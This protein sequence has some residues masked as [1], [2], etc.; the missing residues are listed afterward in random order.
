MEEELPNGPTV[1]APGWRTCEA[2]GTPKALKSFRQSKA[3]VHDFVCRGCRQKLQ[4]KRKLEKLESRACENFLTRA[5]DSLSGG[6]NIP[7]TSELLESIMTLFGGTQGFASMLASQY[8]AAPPGGRIRTSVLEMI[9]RL[10]VKVAESGATRA[11]VSLM[12]DEELEVELNSRLES[13]V[14]QFKGNRVLGIEKVG[15]PIEEEIPDG[16]RSLQAELMRAQAANS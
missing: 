1:A 12:S 8:H 4:Q 14:I 10:T 9:T 2:C 7:H 16:G 5:S 13:A 15:S 11:P 3:G 6:S